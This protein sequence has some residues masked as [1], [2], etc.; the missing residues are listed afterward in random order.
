MIGELAALTPGPY[1]HIGGDEA[2]ATKAADYV[3]VH[4]T[5]VQQIV[6]GARQARDRLAGDRRRAGS[7]RPTVVA[8]LGH[9]RRARP[10]APQAAAQGAKVI[11]S[12]GDHAYLDMKYDPSTPLGQ[13]WAGFIEV[14]DAYVWD[15][16]TLRGG[17]RGEARA[18]RRGAALDGD[19]QTSA[20]VEYMAFPRLAGDRRDRLVAARGR[21]G[22]ST[23]RGSAAQGP[24]WRRSA[25]TTTARRRCPGSNESVTSR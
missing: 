2:A 10:L 15:P 13:D 11:M 7:H 1:I 24:R 23:G 14:R 12:P 3:D 18:R 5:R 8:V 19:L 25:S 21:T 20:D 6:A 4:A 22:R 17:R 9:A 16:A